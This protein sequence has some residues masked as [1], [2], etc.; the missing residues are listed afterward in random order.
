MKIIYKKDITFKRIDY[1]KKGKSKNVI[2]IYVFGKRIGYLY[3]ISKEFG[4]KVEIDKY[5]PF[6]NLYYRPEVSNYDELRNILKGQ[7][8]DECMIF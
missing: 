2:E 6:E 1:I 3:F 8:F 5:A 7:K 4:Y